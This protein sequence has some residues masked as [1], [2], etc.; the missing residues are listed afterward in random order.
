MRPVFGKSPDDAAQTAAFS[1]TDTC[2]SLPLVNGSS[3]HPVEPS[4]SLMLASCAIRSNRR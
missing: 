1:Q 4:R 3:F 2:S